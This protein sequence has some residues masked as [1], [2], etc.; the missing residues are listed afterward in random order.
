[1]KKEETKI[2]YVKKSAAVTIALICLIMGFAGGILYK[3]LTTTERK[4]RKRKVQQQVFQ[5]P[6]PQV[7]LFKQVIALQKKVVDNPK[8]AAAWAGLGNTYFDMN[9]LENA[10]QAY[11]KHLELKP[12]NT[13]VWTDLGIMY[14]RWG[15]PEEAIKAFDKAIAIDPGHKQSRF[16]KGIVY[17][18][19]MKN[20]AEALKTWEELLKIDPGARSSDG[21]SIK[22][23]VEQLRK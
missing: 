22:K 18:H 13:G 19:D 5:T 16:N 11:R 3:K 1:M 10:I 4:V 20:P 21:R 6:P 9:E 8:D 12:G 7:N 23:L 17:L 14:R 15:K 2:Q